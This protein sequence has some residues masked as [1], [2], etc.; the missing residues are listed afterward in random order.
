[1]DCR[2]CADMMLPCFYALDFRVKFDS[3]AM[4][5]RQSHVDCDQIAARARERVTI[6]LD[7]FLTVAVC[8]LSVHKVLN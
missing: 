2:I 4:Q 1:M 6:L 8:A 5:I 7:H 3:N